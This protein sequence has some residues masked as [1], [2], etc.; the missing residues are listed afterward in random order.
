[1]GHDVMDYPSADN[2]EEA[3]IIVS[4]DTQN[5]IDLAGNPGLTP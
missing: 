3:N 4:S 2:I 1:M 5:E